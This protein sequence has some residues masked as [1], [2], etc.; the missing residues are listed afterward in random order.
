MSNKDQNKI[1]ETENDVIEEP[2][3]KM[4]K[5]AENQKT[6]ITI[7]TELCAQKKIKKPIFNEIN[8]PETQQKFAK[9]NCRFYIQVI[10]LGKDA[11]G[12]GSTKK[13]AKHDAAQKLLFELNPKDC[14]DDND[15]DNP[16]YVTQLLDFCVRKDYHKP[17]FN[18]TERFGESHCP[19]FSF[20]CILDSIR[21][22]AS[23]NSKKLAKQK[24]AKACLEIFQQIYP[25]KKNV[26]VKSK[27]EQE[28]ND[29]INKKITTYM[30]LKKQ[31]KTELMGTSIAKRHDFFINYKHEAI[32]IELR[33][34]LNENLEDKTKVTKLMEILGKHFGSTTIKTD[35]SNYKKFEMFNDDDDA[36]GFSESRILIA[37][38]EDELYT[39]IINYFTIML[40]TEKKKQNEKQTYKNVDLT[41]IPIN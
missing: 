15:E 10:A 19:I 24:A 1:I 12:A 27:T 9:T 32:A 29:E 26:S 14:D 25:I 39:E 36:D 23:A 41:F 30:E 28:I 38:S 33:K 21:V 5:I 20:E 4:I 7:L 40:D 2:P 16:D 18:E 11:I 22:I 37:K 3:S 31:N 13:Q 34:I 8:D 6:P 35:E 17:Q